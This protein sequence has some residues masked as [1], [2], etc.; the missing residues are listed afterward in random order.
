MLHNADYANK[1]LRDGGTFCAAVSI[2]G[3]AEGQLPKISRRKSRPSWSFMR[4][5]LAGS[6]PNHPATN[7]GGRSDLQR[8]R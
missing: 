7:P 5:A 6:L 4:S 2:C 1:P 8:G 3:M